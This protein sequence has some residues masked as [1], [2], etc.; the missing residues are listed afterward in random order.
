MI[1]VGPGGLGPVGSDAHIS[2]DQPRLQIDT[3]ALRGDDSADLA[4]IIFRLLDFR[5]ST[6]LRDFVLVTPSDRTPGQIYRT[7]IER[8]ER[9]AGGELYWDDYARVWRT[10]GFYTVKINLWEGS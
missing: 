3:W 2:A 9:N 1:V 7:K 5:F 6:G 4:A 10:S 8:C